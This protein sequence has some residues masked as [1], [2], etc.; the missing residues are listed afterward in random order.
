MSPP[1]THEEREA[2]RAA[3]HQ[4]IRWRAM[5]Q[6][7]AVARAEGITFACLACRADGRDPDGQHAV[8]PRHGD[9]YCRLVPG[10]ATAIR[11][12][13]GLRAAT[14]SDTNGS[15][16]GPSPSTNPAVATLG[17]RRHPALDIDTH[18]V[19]IGRVIENKVQ[20]VTSDRVV[21]T[22]TEAGAMLT[23]LPRAY[24]DL[25]SRWPSDDVDAFLAGG[26]APSL[27]AT[28]TMT[29]DAFN[30]AMEFP[31]RAHSALLATW[32]VSTY[33]HPLFLSFPRLA[34]SGEREAG[35]SK[36]LDV[37]HE[38]AW[39]ALL[40]LSP[41]PA[42]LFRLV[43]T[44]RPTLLLDEM[45]GLARDDKH[46][47]I[48]ILNSGYRAGAT[49][50][51]VEGEGDKRVVESYPV[52]CPVAMAAIRSPNPTLEDRCIPIV[53]A[54]G[55]DRAKLNAEIDPDD[56]RWG[57]IRAACHRVLLTRW[58][59]VA[60]TYATVEVPRWL[61]G[62]AR[63]LWK[64]LLTVARVAAQDDMSSSPLILDL[65]TLARAHVAER[66]SATP[67]GEA[68]L[69]ELAER[70]ELVPEIIA[71]PEELREA[72]GRRL[73]WRD[74]P[75]PHLV[76]GW[77]RRLGFPRQGKDRDGAKYAVSRER[78]AEV[79]RRH[80]SAAEDETA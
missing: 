75:T 7:H 78:L 3:A 65:L 32:S 4:T 69:A 64:P 51:R 34:L 58:R 73:G 17:R 74:P 72:L 31:H 25:E 60:T 40:M 45:E 1:S 47:V 42:V 68:L 28:I 55:T 71:R 14:P 76:A 30:A 8:L 50:P 11:K 77:L 54:R 66:P 62:R 29:M 12:A 9:P 52:Y 37:L 13:L 67:E 15:P 59:E 16:P 35:K 6:P 24:P 44:W 43:A 5:A 36:V 41:T 39:M 2:Q 22:A 53:L 19:S 61:N 79:V 10:H 80:G 27:A 57:R 23:S 20:I 46:E 21:I 63:E 38:T 49:V 48:A 70:L 33:L 26:A 18:Q 56:A